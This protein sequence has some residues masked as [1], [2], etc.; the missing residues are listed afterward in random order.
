MFQRQAVEFHLR[1]AAAWADAA[2]GH[3]LAAQVDP[4]FQHGPQAPDA[5]RP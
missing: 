4:E 2:T 1:N 5:V 3:D